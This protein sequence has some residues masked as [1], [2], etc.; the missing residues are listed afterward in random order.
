CALPIG[1]LTA[2]CWRDIM[3]NLQRAGKVDIILLFLMVVLAVTVAKYPSYRY[4]QLD[5]LTATEIQQ[6]MITEIAH[7]ARPVLS[8]DMV[9]LVRAGQEIQ[10]EPQIFGEL[11]AT[12]RWDQN[13]FL[14]LLS[15]HAFEFVVILRPS[16]YT[17]EMLAV[18]AQAYPNIE[19][20]GPYTIHRR[21]GSR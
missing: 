15:N 16:E 13:H 5:N 6:H 7:A 3:M 11:S 21:A 20:I 19:Q 8:H 4:P 14:Q 9:L 2:H 1:I 17:S 12:G 10:I 18:I